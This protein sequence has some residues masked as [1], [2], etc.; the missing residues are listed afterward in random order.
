MKANLERELRL[1]LLLLNLVISGLV[2]VVTSLQS[3]AVFWSIG[4]SCV[5]FYLLHCM[6]KWQVGRVVG[7]FRR[8]N[9][10]LEAIQ[11]TDYNHQVK[12][13][14]H[15]GE[16]AELEAQMVA[17]SER[18]HKDKTRYNRQSFVLY[19]LIDKLPSPIW[20]FNEKKQLSY[21]N[22]AFELI[23]HQSWHTVQGHTAMQLDL[24]E[25]Q[26]AWRFRTESRRVQW[27]LHSSEFYEQ[28]EC[29]RLIIATDIRKVLRH[30]ELS[31]WQRLIR[32]I[33]HEIHNSLSPV[34]SLAQSLQTK[35]TQSR[36]RNALSVIEQRCAHL[37]AFVGRYSQISKPLKLHREKRVLLDLLMSIKKLFSEMYE[38]QRIDLACSVRYCYCDPQLLE[39]V[40]I[41]LIKNA[42]EANEA[43]NPPR[44]WV[45]LNAFYQA[46][47]VV[48]IVTDQGGGF[49][50]LENATT[51]FYSTKSDGQ[52]IGI[53]LSRH[54][55]EQHGGD[56][57][58]S[59][60][61]QG[62]EIKIT[63]PN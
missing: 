2:C 10:Q 45:G 18:L 62:A 3:F 47:H 4:V 55:I 6:A 1:Y 15:T 25:C 12:P 27:T 22:A 5:S 29:H 17:L 48:I 32:V 21:A 39:Q 33:G 31:A 26:G 19:Q 50:N 46:S 49:A 28:G 34:S 20:V 43:V 9:I 8:V 59:N 56:L 30:Q 42:F 16:A 38:D 24:E 41:N 36:D 52:G 35:I 23:Y 53:T 14:F 37:Q 44:H 58:V 51:P 57:S 61:L 40:L 11:Q 7:L 60:G 54:I 63:L 13:R